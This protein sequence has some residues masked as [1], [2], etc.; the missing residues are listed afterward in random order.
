MPV[1]VQCPNG[2]CNKAFKA[3]DELRG[4]KI[5]CPACGTVITIPTGQ[6]VQAAVRA[7][8]A[9]AAPAPKAKTRPPVEA[10]DAEYEEPVR[11][12]PAAGASGNPIPMWVGVGGLGVLAISVFLPWFSLGGPF[13]ASGMS[14]TG[15]LIVLILAVA[16]LALVITMFVLKKPL[17]PTFLAGGA[18]GTVGLLTTL[19]RIIDGGPGL[20]V[21]IGLVGALGG[22]GAFIFCSLKDPYYFPPFNKEGSSPFL[23][24]FGALLGAQGIALILGLLMMFFGV[25]SGLGSMPSFGPGGGGV[26]NMPKI[27]IDLNNPPF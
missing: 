17:G 22:L 18:A 3:K 6:P 7:K 16:A 8:G 20:G 25:K 1:S 26:P 19:G 5:K 27:K 4:K 12:R 2:E 9:A 21:W 13:S 15:G 23:R 24:N 14:F 10:E 11:R